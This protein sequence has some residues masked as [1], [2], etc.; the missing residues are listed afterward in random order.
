VERHCSVCKTRYFVTFE[1]SEAA[2]ER[3]GLTVLKAVWTE[4]VRKVEA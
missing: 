1:I 3:T 4:R 2:S